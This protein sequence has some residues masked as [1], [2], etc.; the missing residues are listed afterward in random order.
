MLPITIHKQTLRFL[1]LL[2][3]SLYIIACGTQNSSKLGSENG[4]G[5][6]VVEPASYDTIYVQREAL[7]KDSE[8]ERLKRKYFGAKST[9]NN[10]AVLD[11]QPQI[12]G[13]PKELLDKIGYPPSLRKKGVSGKSVV[14]FVISPEG[15]ATNIKILESLHPI[16]DKKIINALLDTQFKPGMINNEAVPTLVEMPFTLRFI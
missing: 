14:E 16:L 8:T 1:P 12:I 2:I 13:E 15:K 9:S 3:L 7:T 4:N 5:K 6:H 10:N 11:V